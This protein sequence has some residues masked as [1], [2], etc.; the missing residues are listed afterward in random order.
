MQLAT[1]AQ[2]SICL[3]WMVGTAGEHG[4]RIAGTSSAE[5]AHLIG[6]Q[7]I[8]RLPGM[9]LYAITERG[10]QVLA[11]ATAGQEIPLSPS[12]QLNNDDVKV[13]HKI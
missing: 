3:S 5:I 8:K 13:V 11:E 4:R 2:R 6:A 9:K 10:R 1:I 12:S 7:Y